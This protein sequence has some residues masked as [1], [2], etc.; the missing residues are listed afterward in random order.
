MLSRHLFRPSLHLLPR[1]R[2]YWR[3]A[4]LAESMVKCR[5]PFKALNSWLVSILLTATFFFTLTGILLFFAITDH[6]EFQ[7]VSERNV[8]PV[9]VVT[10]F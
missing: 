3:W 5:R 8:L 7:N 9:N 4:K 6:E 2:G 10:Y 1:H